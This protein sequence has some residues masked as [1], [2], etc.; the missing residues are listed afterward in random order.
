MIDVEMGLVADL[1]IFDDAVVFSE[2]DTTLAIVAFALGVVILDV[3]V[4]WLDAPEKKTH[5]GHKFIRCFESSS[6]KVVGGSRHK[7]AEI[8]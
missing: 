6:S 4:E 1:L 3:V 5:E 2:V 7:M 8:G